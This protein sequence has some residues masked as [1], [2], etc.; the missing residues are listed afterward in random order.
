M[1]SYLH[2]AKG[3]DPV[4]DAFADTVYSDVY[5]M[6]GQ[7]LIQF[8]IIKGVGT[9][10]TSTITVEGCDNVTPSTTAAIVF[11]YQAITTADTHGAEVAAPVAGFTTT[12]GSSQLYIVSV[13]AE[14]L[15]ALGYEFVRLKAVEVV[16]APVLGGIIAVFPEPAVNTP[17]QTS[18]L[19]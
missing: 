8:I 2:L 7:N 13:E 17:V 6:R 14:K 4:A 10:G 1:R 15:A 11:K 18:V 3:I 19:S 12:A 5:S 9:T 16:N